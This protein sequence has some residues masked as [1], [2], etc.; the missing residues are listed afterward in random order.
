M[1]D[2]LLDSC[3]K[4]LNIRTSSG[5]DD[6]QAFSGTGSRDGEPCDPYAHKHLRQLGLD[7]FLFFDHDLTFTHRIFR[8]LTHLILDFFYIDLPWD[9][10]RNLSSLT[11]LAF[12]C[13]DDSEQV[14]LEYCVTLLLDACPANLL[15]LI[16]KCI[17]FG[18]ED[19]DLIDSEQD[20]IIP[21][22]P[23][24]TWNRH[25]PMLDYYSSTELDELHLIAR[26]A[27]GRVDPRLVV[28]CVTRLPENHLFQ[29]E[30]IQLSLIQDWDE[31]LSSGG[32]HWSIAESI[33]EKR[34]GR[35]DNPVVSWLSESQHI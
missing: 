27:L 1:L 19:F 34:R 20:Y 2:A 32:G 14:G 25:H 31:G 24:E 35:T 21:K 13:I 3:S 15:V 26:M 29:N 10:L 30:V 23:F 9:T 11:H 12:N 22:L 8:D 4:Q 16:V 33:I 5:V 18:N 6:C 17:H 7:S 28:G